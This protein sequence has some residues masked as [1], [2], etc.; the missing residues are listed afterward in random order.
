MKLVA[1]PVVI[2]GDNPVGA[3]AHFID[4]DA[5]YVG[6]KKDGCG[7]AIEAFFSDGLSQ[8]SL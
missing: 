6:M 2:L 1:F 3:A 7:A 5:S 8:I 4:F